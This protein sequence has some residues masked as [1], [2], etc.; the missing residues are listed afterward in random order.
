MILNLRAESL[1]PGI[2]SLHLLCQTG[3]IRDLNVIVNTSMIAITVG[4]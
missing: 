4:W 1:C 3:R 2:V